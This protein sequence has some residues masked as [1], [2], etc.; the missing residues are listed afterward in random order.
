MSEERVAVCIKVFRSFWNSL[1]NAIVVGKVLM[2][3]VEVRS[4]E[5]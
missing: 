1:L 2:E 4:E 3:I 5:Y